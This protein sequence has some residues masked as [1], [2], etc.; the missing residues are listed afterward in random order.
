MHHTFNRPTKQERTARM[1]PRRGIL[2]T[3]AIAATVML[4]APTAAVSQ[5]APAPGATDGELTTPLV[6]DD[7]A[8]VT[9]APQG[10]DA[11]GDDAFGDDAADDATS[12]S[13]AGLGG[14][15]DAARAVSGV[16]SPIDPASMKLQKGEKD[17]LWV[18]SGKLAGQEGTPVA[19][20]KLTFER[21]DG[22]T[23]IFRVTGAK[24]GGRDVASAFHNDEDGK[25]GHDLISVDL[26]GANATAG[27]DVEITYMLVDDEGQLAD[28][29]GSWQF[30]PAAEQDAF[31]YSQPDAAREV[32]MTAAPGSAPNTPSEAS[33]SPYESIGP[34]SVDASKYEEIFHPKPYRG[35]LND[36]DFGKG[37]DQDPPANDPNYSSKK[38]T[39][40]IRYRNWCTQYYGGTNGTDRALRGPYNPQS[41]VGASGLNCP[42]YKDDEQGRFFS[43]DHV[44]WAWS[45]G[46]GGN[47]PS[48]RAEEFL[49]GGGMNDS[50]WQ[51]STFRIGSMAWRNAQMDVRNI[52]N[53]KN[54]GKP[55]FQIY[56]DGVINTDDPGWKYIELPADQGKPHLYMISPDGKLGVDVTVMAGNGVTANAIGIDFIDNTKA[57]FNANMSKKQ[58]DERWQKINKQDKDHRTGIG[59]MRAG[60]PVPGWK[61][62]VIRYGTSEGSNTIPHASANAYRDASF[63]PTW[64]HGKPQKPELTVAKDVA[65]EGDNQDGSRYVD[66]TIA[67]ENKGGGSTEY[68]LNDKLGFT[69]AAEVADIAVIDG[70]DGSDRN[71][72]P[73]RNADGTFKI[74][75]KRSV[76][77]G[78]KHTY[79]VRVTYRRNSTDRVNNNLRCVDGQEGNGLYNKATVTAGS[80]ENGIKVE[81]DACSDLE[82]A[83]GPEITKQVLGEPR[84]LEDGVTGRVEYRVTV[85]NRTNVDMPVVITD[86]PQFADNVEIKRYELGGQEGRPNRDG[87]YT[88]LGRE[89]D[90]ATIPAKKRYGF[91]VVVDF[92]YKD[93]AKAKNDPD[94]Q[95]ADGPGHGLYN[96]ARVVSPGRGDADA[97]ACAPVPEPKVPDPKIAKEVVDND[98]DNGRITY[99]ISVDNR[100]SG[101]PRKIKVV[102]RLGFTD[103]V[104]IGEARVDDRP[105]RVQRDGTFEVTGRDGREAT[106]EARE[107]KEY[108]VT[109]DYTSKKGVREDTS[110]CTGGA[111]GSGNGLFNEAE[112][113]FGDGKVKDFACD[114][115]P[116]P[117]RQGGLAVAK[118]DT[119]GTRLGVDAG[120]AFEVRTA[121]GRQTVAG[122]D[123]LLPDDGGRI[124]ATGG[125]ALELDQEYLLV[126]TRSPKGFELLAQP[127]R[128]KLVDTDDGVVTEILDSAQHPEAEVAGTAG[129][130]RVGVLTVADVRTGT[131]PKSGG[132]G[133]AWWLLAG[134]ALLGA[135]A[136]INRRRA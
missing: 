41:G 30:N 121:D 86:R 60:L 127:I 72:R 90:P 51:K 33:K 57:Q 63:Q 122:L 46:R 12:E 94:A 124:L 95:C 111:E 14:V 118:T 77:S 99:R 106:V 125:E 1:T 61:R 74:A 73:E 101:A 35:P 129:N 75:E 67:V 15:A 92:S 70:P 64:G 113:D 25:L 114:D 105:V 18:I 23:P 83:G 47:A 103:T 88:V 20:G 7:D 10:V 78:K 28:E 69:D 8:D 98:T 76:A 9:V 65:R 85:T 5:E 136:V 82:R 32:V 79:T 44:H 126:E 62:A 22:S 104:E 11:I 54:T 130:G 133:V 128:F 132:N 112:L 110:K 119:D 84:L 131:L 3:V 52:T 53:Y 40:P 39:Y 108:T 81:D 56:V 50:L 109:V 17:G 107:V 96:T 31:A 115:A 49:I 87:R 135:A 16:V 45:E 80:G 43:R 36:P 97:D 42:L 37:L 26:A 29:H 19:A 68:D 123:Q 38:Y 91:K 27:E 116:A 6:N 34:F 48:Y 93:F 21:T 120:H 66:Y 4:L 102:D 2:K 71:R 100:E 117:Q 58:I 24:V 89:G 55:G 134:V 13:G 59:Q